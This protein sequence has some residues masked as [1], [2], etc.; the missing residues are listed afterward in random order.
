MPDDLTVLLGIGPKI[1]ETLNA[2]GITTYARLGA[3]SPETLEAIL[4]EA[5]LRLFRY[6]NSWPEQARLAAE[7]RM[8]DLQALR[9]R[10]ISD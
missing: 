9:A 2:A 7:G 8:D 1:A 5:G 6:L 3:T 4:H 10:L